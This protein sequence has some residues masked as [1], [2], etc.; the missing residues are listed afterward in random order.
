MGVVS[1]R[2]LLARGIASYWLKPLVLGF[3]P[4][5]NLQESDRISFAKVG[6]CYARLTY[7]S[8]IGKVCVK[9][10]RTDIVCLKSTILVR[11]RSLIGELLRNCCRERTL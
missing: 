1:L 9:R 10:D 5:P 2:L 6:F 11:S 4:Q 8:G 7:E 3:V